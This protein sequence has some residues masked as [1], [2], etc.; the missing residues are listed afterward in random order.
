LME[1]QVKGKQIQVHLDKALDGVMR[2]SVANSK[3]ELLAWLN[4]TS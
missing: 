3:A 4:L 1:H 2:E